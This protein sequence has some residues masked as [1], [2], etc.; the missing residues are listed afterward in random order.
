MTRSATRELN[1]RSGD[2][3]RPLSAAEIFALAS[4]DTVCPR[5]AALILRH[6]ADGELRGLDDFKGAQGYEHPPVGP[7]FYGFRVMVG[8]GLLMLAF[9][10]AGLWLYRRRGW[11]AEALPRPLLWG[12]AGMGFSGWLATL[13]G[14]YVTEIGRQPFI[15]FGLIRVDEVA[16]SVPSPMI[17]TTLALYL[18]V[19]LA[20]ITAYVGVLKTL[21]EKPVV[22]PPGLQPHPAR[23]QEAL[24]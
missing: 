3:L 19:Y 24:A 23:P 16:S 9:S 21:A 15:V 22:L 8:I 20:L 4:A 13:A 2:A 10:W 11:Q 14:W 1:D 6:D 18:T 7:L 5:L 12:L 17:A